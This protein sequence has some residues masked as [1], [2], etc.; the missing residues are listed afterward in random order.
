[1]AATDTHAAIEEL[2]EAVFSVRS[3]PRLYNKNQSESRESLQAVSQLRV[4]VAEVEDSSGTSRKR[5][6]CCWQPLPNN[7]MKT[8]IGNTGLCVTVIS[9][10]L[11]CAD[12]KNWN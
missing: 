1:M 6:V 10:N 4:A 5:N 3:L 7:A 9:N 8:M 12:F 2:L 11:K